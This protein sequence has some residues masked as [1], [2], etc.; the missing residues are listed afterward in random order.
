MSTLPSVARL[1]LVDSAIEILKANITNGTW[2][3]GDRLP[4]EADLAEQLG[5]GRNSVREAVR[6][7][8]YAGILDVKQGDGTFVR[9]NVDATETM[10]NIDRAAQRDHL[11]LQCVL[12]TECARL[13]AQRRT[14]EDLVHLQQLLEARGERDIHQDMAQ[15]VEAD[16]AFHIGIAGATH[17]QALEALYRYFS[18]SIQSTVSSVL[19]E[20]D[21]AEIPEPDMGA[22]AAILDAIRDQD[23][24]RA[25]KATLALLQPQINWLEV[26]ALTLP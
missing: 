8:A 5:I 24:A 6:T 18:S 3:V 9:R 16:R 14:E 4:R 10:R 1:S 26:R 22:H 19:L 23:E 20:F 7:L 2:R 25:V 11:E 12:E 15:F 13:A 17:N 21:E